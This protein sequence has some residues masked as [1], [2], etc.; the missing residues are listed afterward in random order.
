MRERAACVSLRSWAARGSDQELCSP[1][2]LNATRRGMSASSTM[3]PSRSTSAALATD[4]EHHEV[5]VLTRVRHLAWRRRLDV[6]EAAGPEEAPRRRPRPEPGPMHEVQLVLRVVVVVEAG[7]AGRHHDRVHAEGGHA[8][9]L[10]DLAEAVPP[11][12]ARRAFRI[13]CPMLSPFPGG[14][15][16]FAG[17]RRRSRPRARS[18]AGG[19]LRSRRPT[20]RAR[21]P[22]TSARRSSPQVCRAAIRSRPR[23]R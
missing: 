9:R 19:Q 11:R 10:A 8:E 5:V 3:W 4:H 2:L 14:S 20:T 17:G 13:A 22:H 23:A 12:R 7:V 16:R 6:D 21:P 1:E 18:R 15:R